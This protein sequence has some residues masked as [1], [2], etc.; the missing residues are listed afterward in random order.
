MR[1]VRV[2]S[3]T[4]MGNECQ[5]IDTETGQEIPSVRAVKIDMEVGKV[6]TA[7]LEV[8]APSVDIEAMAMFHL[9]CPHCKKDI[10]I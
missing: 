10:T 5:V 1:T 2:I 7:I 3:K 6:N 9:T 8:V 4:A